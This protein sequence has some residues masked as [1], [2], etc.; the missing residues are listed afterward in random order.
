M[1]I[2]S[3]HLSS[4]WTNH[5]AWGSAILAS[6]VTHNIIDSIIVGVSVYVITSTLKWIVKKIQELL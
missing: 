4:Y 1:S 3:E 5:L 2:I 6:N